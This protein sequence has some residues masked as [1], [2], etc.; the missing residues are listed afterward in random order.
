MHKVLIVDDEKMIVSSLVLGFDWKCH[1]F[2]VIATASSGREALTLI[3]DLRPDV[4]F[5]DVKMPG[6]SGLELMTTARARQPALV[7]VVISGYA[8]FS[9]AQQALA[10]GA[11]AYCLKPL[12]KEALQ[13]ALEKAEKVLSDSD[14]LR[15]ATL[16]RFLQEPTRERAGALFAAYPTGG[17]VGIGLSVGSAMALFTGNLPCVA[18]ALDAQCSLYI[19]P[20]GVQYL[21]GYAFRAALLG[22][23]AEGRLSAFV[24]DAATDPAALLCDHLGDLLDQLYTFFFH[25]E[26]ATLGKA[27]PIAPHDSPFT[28]A[29][30]LLANKNRP[31]EVLQ[32]LAS[33]APQERAQLTM[34]DAV[35]IDNLCEALLCRLRNLPTHVKHRHGFELAARYTT[36]DSMLQALCKRLER[37]SSN[38]F[39]PERVH[40]ETLAHV[41][42]YL[43][44]HFTQRL[45]YQD[46]CLLH[47]IHPNYLSQ[48]F[49]KEIGVSYTGYLTQLRIAYA[50]ELLENTSALISEI[51]DRV[52]Y[53]SYLHFTKLFKRET[54][55]TPTQYRNEYTSA[56]KLQP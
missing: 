15:H 14:A 12:E 5:T 29:L 46:L 27:L 38:A 56:A 47:H 48:L 24:Y 32:H 50:K 41:I 51:S 44:R 9:F 53:D 34:Q 17:M 40:N 25:K 16:L 42:T 6:M 1:G 23:V 10:L 8:D 54:G 13:N 43:N 7:F 37:A 28:D 11:I 31:A 39:D 55:R 19:F 20:A 21:A 49:K 18:L 2:E 52:G 30:A 36:F 33:L 26:R 3:D 22:A 4:V 35:R 45:S